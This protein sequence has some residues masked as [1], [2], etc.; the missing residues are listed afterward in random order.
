MGQ[1]RH[2]LFDSWV[3]VGGEPPPG[4]PAQGPVALSPN[5]GERTAHGDL[6]AMPAAQLLQAGVRPPT[7][8]LRSTI[9]EGERPREP[10]ESGDRLRV[11]I[12]CHGWNSR[13]SATG[14][15]IRPETM[16]FNLRDLRTQNGEFWI[17][18]RPGVVRTGLQDCN[19]CAEGP[20]QAFWAPAYPLALILT[21]RIRR[22]ATGSSLG[23]GNLDGGTG[24]IH[25]V[26][27][28]PP[29]DDGRRRWRD[30]KLAQHPQVEGGGMPPCLSIKNSWRRPAR[31]FLISR[32]V[33]CDHRLAQQCLYFLPL[34]Q[35]QGSFRRGGGAGTAAA[36]CNCRSA[37]ICF[38]SSRNR[39]SVWA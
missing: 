34:P 38:A 35:G 7:S 39:G 22:A 13:C 16:A 6:P 18:G 21:R 31:T 17:P 15:P 11:R 32:R 29:A 26:A 33:V 12:P 5:R 4:L 27:P 3:L 24:R 36:A 9:L 20:Q 28:H 19:C 30:E 23:P 2:A 37:W 8:S 14:R 10:N 25:G 1:L